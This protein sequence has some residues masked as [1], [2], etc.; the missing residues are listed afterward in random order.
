MVVSVSK[1]YPSTGAYFCG[2]KIL[3]ELDNECITNIY[4]VADDNKTPFILKVPRRELLKVSM[5]IELFLLEAEILRYLQCP[6]V[7]KLHNTGIFKN[8]KTEMPY[9]ILE[10]VEGRDLGQFIDEGPG[11]PEQILSPENS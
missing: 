6:H 4:S 3:T 2:H 10:Y 11:E 7:V 9:M 8:R 1:Y 5:C